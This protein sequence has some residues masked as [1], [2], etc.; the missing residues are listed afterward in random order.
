[1]NRLSQYIAGMKATRQ[2]LNEARIS[3]DSNG[4]DR[5]TRAL[6][7]LIDAFG[8]FVTATNNAISIRDGKKPRKPARRKVRP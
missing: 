1:V 3:M 8:S 5:H 4:P 6:R 7:H 2:L